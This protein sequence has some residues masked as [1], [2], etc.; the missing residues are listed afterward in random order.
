MRISGVVRE[1]P[2]IR[3]TGSQ[4]LTFRAI[5]VQVDTDLNHGVAPLGTFEGVMLSVSFRDEGGHHTLGSATLVGPGLAICA[6]HVLSDHLDSIRSGATSV[7]CKGLAPDGL[8]L[9]EVRNITTLS[10]TDLCILSL[11]FRSDLPQGGLAVAHTTTRMPRIGEELLVGGFTALEPTLEVSRDMLIRGD[12]RFSKGRVLD[13]YEEGRDQMLPGPSLAIE[14]PALGGM[15]GG[16]VFDSRGYLVGVL[17]S[18]IEGDS[19]AFVSHIWPALVATTAPVWPAFMPK[20]A[21]LLFLGS[22]HGV[23]IERP[24]AFSLDIEQ[25]RLA[26]RYQSWS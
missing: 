2:T 25:G 3:G 23:A 13:L 12:T 9:W 10:N 8:L 19:V 26:Y 5:A 4:T 15:S 24:D 11:V 14:C 20:E 22:K 17:T 7:I 18:S 1:D 6:Q 16:P 21:S